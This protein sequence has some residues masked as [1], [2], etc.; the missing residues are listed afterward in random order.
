MSLYLAV[1]VTTA[2]P[3][4]V[5]SYSKEIA[6]PPPL[7]RFCPT[8]SGA[9]STFGEAVVAPMLYPPSEVLAYCSVLIFPNSQL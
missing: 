9:P 5:V 8:P 7:Y 4:K 6:E 3:E 1:M 2:P